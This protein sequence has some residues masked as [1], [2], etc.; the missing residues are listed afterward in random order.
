MKIASFTSNIPTMSDTRTYEDFY[1]YLGVKPTRLGVV[2]RMYDDL[3][4]SFLTESLKNIFYQDAKGS[5]NKYQSVNA[6]QYD[7]EIESNYIKRI[8]FAAVPEGDG[9]GGTEIVMAFRERYYE[10]YDTFKIE[11]SGQQCQVI[12]R[13][14]RKGD[15]YWE[16]TVRLVANNYDAVLDLTACQPGDKTRR[17]SNYMPELHEE[18][19]TKW[20]SNV[21]KHR[22]YISTHRVDASYSALYAAQED[23]FIKIAEGK[24]QGSMTETIYHMDTVQKNLLENFLT[25]RNQG[26]LF[27][28]GNVDPVTRKPTIVDPDTNRPIY[29][30]DGIIPQVEAFCSKYAYNKLTISVLKTILQGLN[31]KARKPTGNHYI[32]ICNEKAWY[33]VQDVLD[34]YLANYHTDGT[35]LWSMKANDYVSVGAR[36]FESFNYAGNTLTF[37]VDRTF[38]REYGYEKGYMLALDL[39]ADKTSAQP[40]IAMFTLKDGD[41][42]SNKYL[43]VGKENGLTS[44]E[45][46]SPVAGSKLILWGYSGVAVFNPYRSYIARE[47]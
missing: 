3:T 16:V 25:A 28:K 35:Y 27:S 9:A 40:P 36:G 17:I 22:G 42:I 14:T 46:A 34:Q 15:N 5:G 26:M 37:H 45:V 20:Q 31:E 8:E 12:S 43:G 19:Y 47:I 44:G 24:D 32:F 23:V 18:G 11:N 21:E 4:A 13:P 6:L 41:M 38:S 39:T 30:S 33:D 1:K 2:S 7:W 10:K 29:I